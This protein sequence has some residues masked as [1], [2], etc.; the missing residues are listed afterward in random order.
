MEM[1]MTVQNLVKAE[2]AVALG[3]R[4]ILKQRATIVH[5]ERDG[6][7]PTQARRLLATFESA[8]R[9]FVQHR[10]WLRS[11]ISVRD[12]A[13]EVACAQPVVVE[14]PSP[15]RAEH[16]SDA[17]EPE[18]RAFVDGL[19]LLLWRANGRGQRTWSGG[20]WTTYTGLTP[21]DSVGLGWLR[22]V[23][24][25]D[26]MAALAALS[27][28]LGNGPRQA[29]YRIRCKGGNEYSWFRTRVAGSRGPP[30]GA[31]DWLGVSMEI[32]DLREVGE[33]RSALRS[34]LQRRIRKTLGIMR[35]IVRRTA[36]TSEDVE[37]YAI[38]FEGRLN[39]LARVQTAIAPAPLL[40]VEL[41]AL[42][43]EQILALGGR[44]DDRVAISGS[45]L[46]LQPDAA[47]ILGLGIHE[48][49]TNAM[50]FGALSPRGGRLN[51][52]WQIQ[53]APSPRLLLGWK[54]SK[55]SKLDHSFL[56]RGFGVDFLE[57][58]LTYELD[59]TTVFTIESDGLH[60][61]IE[62]PLV[63]RIIAP[64]PPQRPG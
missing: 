53:Q 29:D 33:E 41:G 35:S 24:P 18:F 63:E 4:N 27:Q 15:S 47:E 60:C 50:K 42:I 32:D 52:S 64:G 59:A 51:V 45:P 1:E 10:D 30:A 20:Y 56:R 43:A 40:G 38:H 57:K 55:V 2:R 48:L 9:L 14:T 28:G 23:H 25:D 8:Q 37:D 13:C 22:A 36:E 17:G 31:F 6:H 11:E 34:E 49:A 5:L 44:N 12:P 39:A 26:R 16:E 3:K 21:E 62:I 19:P 54:E 58:T 61:T 46:R 7:D